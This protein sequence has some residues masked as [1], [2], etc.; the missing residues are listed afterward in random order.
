MIPASAKLLAE[1]DAIEVW[2]AERR[3]DTL[4]RIA[5]LFLHYADGL[6]TH[7]I[8][9]FDDVFSRL[10][11]G[12]DLPSLARLGQQLSQAK[13]ALPQSIRKLA[14]NENDS[15]ATP[16]LKSADI[17]P[18]TLLEAARSCPRHR[19]TIARRH[20]LDPSV[21]EVLIQCGDTAVHHAL[22]ENLS[23]RL[24]EGSWAHLVQFGENDE[25][26]AEKLARR[27]DLQGPLKR[28]IQAKVQDSRMRMLHAL[29]QVMRDQI[30]NTIAT[31]DKGEIAGES[32]TPDYA[33]ALANMLELNRKGKLND[34]T[35]NRFAVCRDY[36]NVVAALAFLT[37]SPVES[38]QPLVVSNNA[39]GLVLACKASRLNWSTTTMVLKHRPVLAQIS[40]EE[41]DKA[42]KTFET[43]SLS[44][45]QRTMRF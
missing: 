39:D 29:P 3:A 11:D 27:S 33:A 21:S 36:T 22:A 10:I 18:E 6:T 1:F 34:S 44:A 32:E 40:P 12:V 9:L 4:H 14:F 2:P 42:K 20:Q 8:T 26:L 25:A 45:A 19:L 5:N 37:G 31:A 23:A 43:F 24:S 7:Q 13:C 17:A 35:V 28:K 16:I 38:I 30:E 15:V 41:L